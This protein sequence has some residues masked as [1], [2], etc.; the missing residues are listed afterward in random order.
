MDALNFLLSNGRSTEIPGLNTTPDILVKTTACAS[1]SSTE[2]SQNNA[3]NV[4]FSDGN[5]NNNNKYNSN[6]VRAVAALGEEIK[7]GWV[8]AFHDCCRNKKSSYNCNEYRAA[9]WEL[10]LWL[11][12]YE[13]YISQDYTPKPSDCFIVTRPT[14]REIFAANFRDRIVQHWICLRLEPLFD[15]RHREQGDVSHN[16][17]KGY[18]TSSAVSAL[19]RDIIEVSQNYT[20]DAWVAKI[21]IR[22][23]F[24]SIDTHI[25]WGFLRDFIN[26]EYHGDDKDTLLYLTE[27]T[28]M[29]RPQEDCIRKSRLEFWDLLAAHKSLFNNLPGIGVAIGNIT[30]QQEANY[31]MSYYVEEI[32]PEAEKRGAKIEQFVD[33]VPCVAP[34][35]ATCLWFR[36]ESER[37]LRD[38]LNL[39]MHPNKFYLQHVKK[40]VNFVGQTIM[41]GRRYISNR[42]VG[43]FVNELKRTEKLCQR[44]IDG[45]F[46]ASTLYELRHHVCS[47]NSYLGFM[48]HCASYRLREKI[49]KRECHAFWQTCYTAHFDICKIKVKYDIKQFLINQEI[50]DYGMDFHRDR[51]KAGRN[52]KAPRTKAK[53]RKLLHPAGG[54]GRLHPQIQVRDS[55][56]GR[57]ALRRNR[58]RD[59]FG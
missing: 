47:I 21:D 8:A 23:F 41:P 35:K 13:I 49:F 42:T 32:K 58:Q 48:I 22:S 1:P 14:L 6:A 37:I 24:M 17:R 19:E 26:K 52:P 15:K 40:G 2:Y 30:S 27:I 54:R 59:Y 29:H 33:D 55:R 12:V 43:N 36:Q 51:A 28:V 20:R 57:V 5:T 39:K 16:C 45:E 50:Q 31:Y 18:G 9:D 4:N 38:K 46:N 56:T 53:N 44:I 25:L 7:E 11:L 10:D 3:W 34:D